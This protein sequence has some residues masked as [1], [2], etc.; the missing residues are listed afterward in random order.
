MVLACQV[1]TGLF[2]WRLYQAFNAMGGMWKFFAFTFVLGIYTLV[3]AGGYLFG[4]DRLKS[5]A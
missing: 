2:S 3:L 1:L 5:T 4:R